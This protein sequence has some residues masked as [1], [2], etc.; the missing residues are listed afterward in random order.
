MALSGGVSA[1]MRGRIAWR[2]MYRHLGRFEASMHL[3]Q[4]QALQKELQCVQRRVLTMIVVVRSRV[5]P[6]L[7]HLDMCGRE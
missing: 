1:R 4:F 6:L 3:R 7:A 5:N 2:S